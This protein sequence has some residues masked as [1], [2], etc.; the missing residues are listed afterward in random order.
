MNER[1]FTISDTG[2]ILPVGA[3]TQ[4][5]AY[6]AASDW[7]R[8]LPRAPSHQDHDGCDGCVGFNADEILG[9]FKYKRYA[10]TRADACGVFEFDRD[11]RDA[12][13]KALATQEAV[14][15]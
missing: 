12:A 11:A 14:P 5:Q 8:G 13:R 3:A 15:A 6:Q 2:D 9:Q 4:R 10:I 1:S 7:V